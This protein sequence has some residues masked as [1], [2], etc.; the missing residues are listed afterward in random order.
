[1][2]SSNLEFLI[3]DD[4]STIKKYLKKTIKDN[5]DCEV[6]EADDAWSALRLIG[7]HNISL[8]LMDVMLGDMSG[9]NLTAKIKNIHQVLRCFLSISRRF[10]ISS[11][12]GASNFTIFSVAGC[13]NSSVWACRATRFMIGSCTADSASANCQG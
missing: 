11:G 5:F 4:S 3:V 13:L 9:V 6:F 7:N 8:I 1:M 10:C 12:K 2:P